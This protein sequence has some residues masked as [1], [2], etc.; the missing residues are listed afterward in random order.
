MLDARASA[1]VSGGA[2]PELHERLVEVVALR[3]KASSAT[4][5]LPLR[6]GC[7]WLFQGGRVRDLDRMSRPCRQAYATG[8]ARH[9][10]LIDGSAEHRN[11][12]GVEPG[13]H[14]DTG[15]DPEREAITSC[16]QK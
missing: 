2:M 3:A 15:D 8:K 13:K 6:S 9:N 1:M 12:E 11:P 5:R 7:N 10:R 4:D 14:G 16:K